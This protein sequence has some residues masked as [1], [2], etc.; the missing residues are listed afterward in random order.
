MAEQDS[1]D[2]TEE[3]TEHKIQEALEKGNVPLS[4]EASTFAQ[5]LAL[6]L[7]LYLFVRESTVSFSGEL[8]FF[9]DNVGG[10]PL[11]EGTDALNLLSVVGTKVALFLLPMV[12]ILGVGG[13]L[14]TILQTP[15]RLTPDK[16][17][18]KWSRLS[19]MSGFKRIYGL[20]GQIEFLKSLVKFFLVGIICF[21]V[22][23]SEQYRVVNLMFGDPSLVPEIVL[24]IA[25]RLVS[26]ICVATV[27]L[28]AADLVWS[29][30]NW[31]REL[32]MTK[33]EIKDEF[34]QMEG[35]P[36][37]KARMRSIA[38]ARARKRMISAVPQASLVV[39]NP[40]HFAIALRY[41]PE[42][43]G[44]PIVLAK[45]QDLIALTIREIAT[46]HDIPI[47]EDKL[48]ARS[49][50]GS[51]EV[52]KAIPPEFYRAVAQLFYYLYQKKL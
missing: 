41:I 1:G 39:T 3:P 25:V 29:R 35:D 14:A 5:L 38:Q 16:L 20:Q 44:A 42:E 2:K 23:I 31:R 17:E 24:G 51:V 4:R 52:D 22:L 9:L 10:I 28:V 12:C 8:Q 43:G 46:K 40:T 19:P 48:L 26:A 7:V 11:N 32:R 30:F 15:L 49:M 6:L 27:I 36:M 37:I 45:G 33:Q 34:K 13:I 47:V 50:Y 21:I 18:P